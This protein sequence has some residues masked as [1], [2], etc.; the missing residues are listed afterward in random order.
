MRAG[1]VDLLCTLPCDRIKGL[2]T[3]SDSYFRRVPLTREEEGMGIAAGAALAGKRPALMIQ[4][5][6]VGNMINALMSLNFYYGLPLAVFVSWRGVYK[7]GIAAQVPMGRA[8]PGLLDALG[9]DSTE[10]HT[11][12]DMGKVA[13]ELNRAYAEGSIHFFLM[14][15]VLWEGSEV[16]GE[17]SGRACKV[18]AGAFDIADIPAP[19]LDRYAVIE[20]AAPALRGEAVVCN[21][22]V[23]AKELY[24]IIEQPS[25]FYMLGS[26]GMA[27]AIGLGLAISTA[28]KIYVI[29]GDGSILMNP[30]TLATAAMLDPGNLFVIAVDNASYGSTG[31]QPTLTGSCV[32]LELLA[33]GMGF[34]H[35]GKAAAAE[36]ILDALKKPESPFFLHVPARAGDR[37]VSQ[38][39]LD[40]EQIRDRFMKF[41]AS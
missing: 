19:A 22:G 39:P 23:P 8:L 30:G 9:L 38:I 13:G 7:E 20:A 41:L 3:L 26:M 28:K 2:L 18:S 4:S 1:G 33:R 37:K 11:A 36:E 15:P 35:T 29:E 32:E 16:M 31:G 27:T 12:E 17:S 25:N 34:R 24:E 21:L 40:A 6:G 14:S 10:L 5:S